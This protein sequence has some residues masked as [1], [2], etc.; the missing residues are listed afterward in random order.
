MLL[1]MRN[2]R[3]GMSYLHASSQ[4]HQYK[5]HSWCLV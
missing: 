3:E 1:H 5:M 4:V 2:L